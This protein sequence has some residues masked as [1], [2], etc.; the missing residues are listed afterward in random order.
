MKIFNNELKDASPER[1]AVLRQIAEKAQTLSE[2]CSRQDIGTFVISTD[3]GELR[4]TN[5][6]TVEK[7][8]LEQLQEISHKN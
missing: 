7:W 6:S 4:W 1:K 2:L 5:G 3:K 8:V